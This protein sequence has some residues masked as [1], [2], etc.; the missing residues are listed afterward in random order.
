MTS[1]RRTLSDCAA[2]HLSPEFLL[3]AYHQALHRGR[4]ARSET[5]DVEQVLKPY[6]DPT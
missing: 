2:S 4:V 5:P 6:L 3:Q 1:T